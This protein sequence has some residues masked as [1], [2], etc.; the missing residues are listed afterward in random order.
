[1]ASD[2]VLH[3]AVQ[4]ASVTRAVVVERDALARL[5]QVVADL[6]PGRPC[7]IVADANTMEA[8]GRR[9]LALL[10]ASQLVVEPPIVL[11]APRRLEPRADIA[12]DVATGLAATGALPVAVG[13]GV[14]NDITKYASEIAR[15]PYV[16]VATA[17]SMDGYAASGAS[18]LDQGFKRT[19]ACAP[20]IAVVADLDVVAHAPPPMASWGYGDLAGKLVAGADWLLADAVGEDPLAPGPFGLVQDNVKQ[21]LSEPARIAAH[22]P[23]A[24]RGLM[25]GLLISGFAMQAHGNSRPASGSDHQLAHVWDMDHVS[26]GGEPAAHGACV[27]VGAVAMTA[28]YE[29]LLAQDVARAV[30]R[31]DADVDRRRIEDELAAAF[32][33]AA[34]GES[35]RAEMGAKLERASQRPARL[36]ALAARWDDLRTAIRETLLP[37]DTLAQWLRACGAAS[38][39]SDL[40]V[41]L[42]KLAADYRRARL[43]RRR[44]TLLDCLEDLGWL[45]RGIAALFTPGGYWDR[46][47]G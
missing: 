9:V 43:I 16:C 33:H 7:R 36:R 11:P 41:P 25:D 46:R 15:T 13:A 45:D 3:R 5:A 1:M 14:I 17:A 29:W 31:V 47:P 34:L 24:L 2:G 28:V 44:Y 35:A 20:P 22:D 40:G 18:M 37:A 10:S 38:H 4:S 19:L 12:R 39:P 26:V 27:G 21:W 42:G 8:A 32:P 30:D 23:G 6:Q